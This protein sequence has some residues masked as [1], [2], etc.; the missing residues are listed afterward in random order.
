MLRYLIRK[1]FF[2]TAF[3]LFL[4]PVTQYSAPRVVEKN[5]VETEKPRW[6][7]TDDQRRAFLNY[8][9]PIIF[10]RA[11][12]GKKE[13]S[14]WDY[15]T[16]WK[17]DGD[18][19]LTNNQLNWEDN[20]V[21]YIHDGM[22]QQF[23]IRPTLYTFII[24]FMEGNTKSALM[25]YHIYH[26]HNSKKSVHDWERIEV[27]VDGIKGNPGSGETVKFVVITTHSYHPAKKYPDNELK[28]QTTKYG[29]HPLIF[30]AE[31]SDNRP[32]SHLMKGELY[33]IKDTVEEITAKK[34]SMVRLNE[35]K[36]SGKNPD[37]SYHYV[38][39]NQ[40][41]PEAVKFWNAQTVTQ[42]NIKTMIAGVSY[43]PLPT[44]RTRRAR[45]ELQD[46][47]DILPTHV[48]A[49]DGS[50]KNWQKKKIAIL[51]ED[52]SLYKNGNVRPYK[53]GLSIQEFY[54]SNKNAKIKKDTKKGY[55]IK[56][57]FWG[58]YYWGNKGNF[59]KNAFESGAPDGT[60]CSAS[61]YA[62]CAGKFWWQHDYYM[63]NGNRLSEKDPDD[64][65]GTWLQ[66]KWYTKERGGF[67]GRWVPLFK[68]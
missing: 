17:F 13:N 62:D 2:S 44:D 37:F 54:V 63:H 1:V 3:F 6:T 43:T 33:F 34:E 20:L 49:K 51:M 38:F 45:Y 15:L 47:A 19:D 67:D 16:S 35:S 66:G 22:F 12:E 21:K 31:W 4:L 65:D 39:V 9:S 55:P 32:T 18:D 42:K 5:S 59:I 29:M 23:N 27:R 48:I 56:Q 10:K 61:G 24:E 40:A 8:Y 58:A 14:G 7:L 36:Y 25:L 52:G 11:N 30:Q 26:A 57:W 28:F 50:N 53:P 41:D 68:D 46:V 64:E 60:R